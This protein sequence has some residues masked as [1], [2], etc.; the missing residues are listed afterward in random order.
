MPKDELTRIM[1]ERNS[2]GSRYSQRVREAQD[3]TATTAYNR[4]V[5]NAVRASVASHQAKANAAYA[6]RQAQKD[7]AIDNARQLAPAF[8]TQPVF[9]TGQIN[10]DPNQAYIG[11]YD[12]TLSGNN[13]ST[14]EMNRRVNFY[15]GLG[16]FYNAMGSGNSMPYI[17]QQAVLQNP[18]L[19]NS[20]DSGTNYGLNNAG[21]N[22]MQGASLGMLGAP[23][24]A[25][26]AESM[27]ISPVT[28]SLKLAADVGGGIAGA[29]GVDAVSRAITGDDYGTMF[30]K[31]LQNYFNMSRPLPSWITDMTNP[32]YFLGG[33]GA[34]KLYNW[35]PIPKY[36]GN[37]DLALNLDKASNTWN[38]SVGYVGS[39]PQNM[40]IS[41]E[42]PYIDYGY[43][44]EYELPWRNNN[45]LS[46]S[47]RLGIPKGE[48]NQKIVYQNLGNATA[49]KSSS[50]HFEIRNP[51]FGERL[52]EGSEQ[53]V[54][55]D[56]S[57][58]EQVLKV[59]SDRGFKS[60]D[61]IRKF[62]QADIFKRNQLPLQERIKIEGYVN[63]GDLKYPVYSQKRLTPIGNNYP[64]AL[65]WSVW[66]NEFVPKIYEVLKEIGYTVVERELTNGKLYLCDI[67]PQNVGYD[68]EGNLRFFDIDVSDQ[69]LRINRVKTST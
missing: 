26:L 67:S 48:R 43:K 22:F 49:P 17:S 50:E 1:A 45:T 21:M 38:G 66:R 53:T 32:G 52:G 63:D 51:R 6:R 68:K 33:F 69:P 56:N 23:V 29:K 35:S 20:V 30:S 27:S 31:K 40:A 19:M 15:N 42:S 25:P 9:N 37:T 65:E 7:A 61:D 44:G 64:S 8:Y 28:T 16:N 24:V 18:N 58:P 11:Q 36:A 5:D 14:D 62:H 39:T 59:Y 10:V 60:I 47:E 41:T 3:N 34:R 13:I 57:D 4:A 12:S 46:L 55:A 2:R 54:F